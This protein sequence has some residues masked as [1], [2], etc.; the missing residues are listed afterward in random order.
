[1]KEQSSVSKNVYGIRELKNG[2]ERIFPIE[3]YQ[4]FQDYGIN[5]ARCFVEIEASEF[6]DEEWRTDISRKI[7]NLN[8]SIG[9]DLE[10]YMGS[11][12]QFEAID[13]FEYINEEIKQKKIKGMTI[14]YLD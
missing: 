6:Y 9:S 13:L 14:F 2:F 11:D 1:L 8:N 7:S 5:P 3:K 4:N 12:S 10:T